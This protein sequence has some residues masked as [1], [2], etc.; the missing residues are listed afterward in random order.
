[1]LQAM[2]IKDLTQVSHHLFLCNGSSC[3]D[4]GAAATTV[5]IREEIHL[6]GL[7]DGLH[8]TK[9]L[10]NGRCDDGPVVIVQPDGV[11]YR[12]VTP[13]IGRRIVR[14][15]LRDGVSVDSQVLYQ[16]GDDHLDPAK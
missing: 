16:W 12:Q 13:T 2:A 11:W 15:H 10:C 9:T 6:C 14:E 4:R 1:M 3:S 7:H 8:T 5:A